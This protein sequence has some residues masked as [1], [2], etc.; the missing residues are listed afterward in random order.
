M[1]H[2][3]TIFSPDE[4]ERNS[5]SWRVDGDRIYGP[6]TIDIKG[7]TVVMFMMLDALKKILPDMYDSTSWQLLF[8]SSEETDSGDFGSLCRERL[9]SNSRACL[10]FEKGRVDARDFYLVTSRKGR[11]VFKIITDGKPAHSGSNHKGGASAIVQMADVIKKIDSLTDYKKDLTVNIGQ[12]FG[13]GVLN[14][15][16]E[17]AEADVEMRAF[18]TEAYEKGLSEILGLDGFSS[19]KNMDG[20]FSCKTRVEPG[21]N[22]P[23]WPDNAETNNLLKCWTEAAVQLGVRVLPEKRGGLSDGNY[24]WD[25]VPA[26]DGLGPAGENAHCSGSADKPEEQEFAFMSSLLPKTLLN[27]LAVNEIEHKK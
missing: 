3:D 13:G 21:K 26:I 25:I 5:F 24:I 10:V 27:I 9:G 14:R 6:G 20:G 11:T 2:L 15:V 23:V 1:S 22:V 16:A 8:S 19:I 17:Y 18:D 7:G 4:E 12:V